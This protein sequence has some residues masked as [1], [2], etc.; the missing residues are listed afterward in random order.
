VPL[1]SPEHPADPRTTSSTANPST[2]RACRRLPTRRP[3]SASIAIT[4]SVLVSSMCALGAGGRP[5][6][7]HL[8][9]GRGP[10]MPRAVVVIVRVAVEALDPFRVTEL[11]EIAQVPACGAPL[12]AKLTA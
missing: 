1:T 5:R 2:K 6:K 10:S 9:S 4:H 7:I 11:G 12:Q 8:G 3:S